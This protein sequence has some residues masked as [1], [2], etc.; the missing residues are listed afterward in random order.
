MSGDG[1][2][3]VP[4]GGAFRAFLSYSHRD[5]A[6]AKWL[7]RA[8]E[9]Y[10]VPARLVGRTTRTGIVGKTA[11]K[12][13]RDRDELS[14]SSDLTGRIN[15]ALRASQFLIVLC[16]PTSAASKWVNQEV[17]NFK[18]L[19][20]AD[21]I[22]AVILDGEPFASDISGRE[23]EECFVPALRFDVDSGGALTGKRAEPIAADLRHGKDSKRLVRMK[24]LAGLLGLELDELIRREVQRRNR[25]LFA[26]S[27][28]MGAIVIA[29]TVLSV[30]AVS[31]RN[32]AVAARDDARRQKDQ[33]EGLIDFMLGDLKDKLKPVGR[34]DSLEA[35]G[36][37][38]TRYFESLRADEVDS[39]TRARLARTKLLAAEVLYSQGRA[40]EAAEQS[41]QA[42]ALTEA[43]QLAEPEKSSR[44]FDHAQSEFWVGYGKFRNASYSAAEENFA[45]YAALAARLV[46]LDPGNLAWR[47]ERASA[48]T[49]LGAVRLQ[50]LHTDAALMDFQAAATDQNQVIAGQPALETFAGEVER[51]KQRTKL[52][53][54]NIDLGQ[55][56]AWEGGARAVAGVIDD[57]IALREQE[58]VVYRTIESLDPANATI[59]QSRWLATRHRGLLRLQKGDAAGALA[60]FRIAIAIAEP[61]SR[62]DQDNKR[63]TQ[64][65]A[66]CRLD[67][68]EALLD[69]G[70]SA[71]AREQLA[72]ALAAR[73]DI[74]RGGT[75]NRAV[76]IQLV[77]K[78]HMVAAR[79]RSVDNAPVAAARSLAALAEVTGE[80]L[81]TTPDEPETLLL[82][83][84]GRLLSGDIASNRRDASAQWVGALEIADQVGANN[85]QGAALQALAARRLNDSQR[86]ARVKPLLC[87]AG[88]GRNELKDLCR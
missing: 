16:S 71:E 83:A 72:L 23:A 49:N 75:I 40:K 41:D 81:K 14:V 37:R 25:Q 54:L 86:L 61:L 70:Q 1:S 18:R 6:A 30:L 84:E 3:A 82:M 87:A 74:I 79:Q 60:D 42:F 7:H 28:A 43:L 76:R 15:D 57:A 46:E 36:G 64:V 31:S 73:D 80:I 68:V 22:I 59:A 69:L 65:L 63:W 52:V 51:S 85:T 10:R 20:G 56:L 66:R 77:A 9:S 24:V 62:R 29:L 53:N 12:I 2:P 50:L 11:G 4:E 67:A 21:S 17:V 19:K 78:S 39:E 32:A 33:A 44:I 48:L 45:H 55:I 88:Y 5:S 8:L 13:F 47:A 26:F 34:L 58:L 38:A 27:C 35:V